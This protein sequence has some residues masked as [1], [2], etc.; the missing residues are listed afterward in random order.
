MPLIHAMTRAS[1]ALPVI[2]VTNPRCR[3]IRK[4]CASFTT[5]LPRK[6]VGAGACRNSSCGLC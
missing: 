2:D 4:A 1:H 3:T 6:N 5:L